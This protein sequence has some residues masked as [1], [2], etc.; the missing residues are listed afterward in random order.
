MFRKL[1]VAGIYP[2]RIGI[3]TFE[4]ICGKFGRIAVGL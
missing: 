4:T 2:D 3:G 1:H